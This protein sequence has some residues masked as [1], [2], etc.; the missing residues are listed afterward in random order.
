MNLSTIPDMLTRF[1]VTIGL[2]DHSM[3]I[4]APIIAVALGARV[5]EKHFCLSGSLGGVDSAFSMEPHE[6]ME[7]AESVRSAF[8]AR[9]DVKYGAIGK[10]KDSVVFRRSVFAVDDVKKGEAF[11][12]ENIRVIRPGHGVKP[13]YYESLL[14]KA[15]KTGYVK[16]NP[17]KEVEL[18]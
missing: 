17:I 12:E 15:S 1:G 18:E 16:G 2:S 13:K 11:T 14:G 6:F 4:V 9:G 5:I 3:G 10:E 8:A 7:M